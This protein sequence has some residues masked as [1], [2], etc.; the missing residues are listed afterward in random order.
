MAVYR[1]VHTSFWQDDF[2]LSL[3]P[4]EKYFYLYLITGSKTS[5][6]GIYELTPRLAAFETGLPVEEVERLLCKFEAHGKVRRSETT[7]EICIV[8]WLRYNTNRSPK[9]KK[10]VADSLSKV[11]DRGLTGYLADIDTLQ[12]PYACPMDTVSPESVSESESESVSS[13]DKAVE[14]EPDAVPADDDDDRRKKEVQSLA[15]L[16]QTLIGGEGD[17]VPAS[18]AKGIAD[19]LREGAE[20]EM[21]RA[22]IELSAENGAR[23]WSYVRAAVRDKLQRGICTLAGFQADQARYG[24]RKQ[25]NARK[26]D[27]RKSRFNNYTDTDKSDYAALED[28]LLEIQLEDGAAAAQEDRKKEL[29]N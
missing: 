20:P 8:N 19:F 9:V 17:S 1:N 27:I 29:I 5:L 6:S 22:A 24:E 7:N 18:V 15:M 26:P 14:A 21:L 2:V 12:I 10:A 3:D 16:Y 28:K 23:G 11:K 4:Q 13:S 25:T